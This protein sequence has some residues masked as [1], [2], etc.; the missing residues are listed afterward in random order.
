[1]PNPAF[2]GLHTVSSFPPS[3]TVRRTDQNSSL[4]WPGRAPTPA[5]CSRLGQVFF[6]LLLLALPLATASHA[7]QL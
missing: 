3:R 4:C 2:F 6:V 1:M 7:G 5:A